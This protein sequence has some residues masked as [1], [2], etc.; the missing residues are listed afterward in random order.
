MKY[1]LFV[2]AVAS[3]ALFAFAGTGVADPNLSPDVPKHRHFVENGGRLVEVGPRLCDNAGLQSAFNQFHVNIHSHFIRTPG[4]TFIPIIGATG[5]IA[6]GL[7]N[8]SGPE[9][10][11][12]SC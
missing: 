3:I 5:P 11:P 10:V 8:D 2:A 9:I 12:G 6:P 4:G 7:N 1:V